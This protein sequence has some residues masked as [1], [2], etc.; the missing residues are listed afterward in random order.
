MGDS[1]FFFRL[2]FRLLFVRSLQGSFPAGIITKGTGGG[3]WRTASVL[4]LSSSDINMHFIMSMPSN[5]SSA[6]ERTAAVMVCGYVRAI[7]IVSVVPCLL[8]EMVLMLVKGF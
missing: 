5:R 8:M 1:G 4:P 6:G 7:A 3:A 2:R